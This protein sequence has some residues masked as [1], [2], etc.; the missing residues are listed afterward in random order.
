MQPDNSNVVSRRQ[1]VRMSQIVAHAVERNQLETLGN[2][3]RLF[4]EW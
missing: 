2:S 1:T 3:L 4:K